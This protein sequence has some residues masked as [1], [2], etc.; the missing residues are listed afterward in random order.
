MEYSIGGEDPGSVFPVR[1]NFTAQG[2]LASVDVDTVEKLSE[3][4]GQVVAGEGGWSQDAIV[5]VDEYLVV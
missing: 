2:S 3:G 4:G 1:A 5:T